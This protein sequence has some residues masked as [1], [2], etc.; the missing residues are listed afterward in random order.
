MQK[1]ISLRIFLSILLTL[2]ITF[3]PSLLSANDNPWQVEEDENIVIGTV[4]EVNVAEIKIRKGMRECSYTPNDNI[5]TAL[6]GTCSG[7]LLPLTD[8]PLNIEAEL[9]LDSDNK[10]KAMRNKQIYVPANNGAVLNGWGHNAS[11]SPNELYYTLYNW[12][13]G[14]QLYR[15]SSNSSPVF[16]SP[17]SV[18][19]WNCKSEIAVSRPDNILIL[20]PQSGKRSILA[21]PKLNDGCGRVITSINWDYNGDKLFYVSLEDY[22]DTESAIFNLTILDRVGRNVGSTIIANLDSAVWLTD[23]LILFAIYDDLEVRSG[24]ILLWN[25]ET[26]EISEFLSTEN[27]YYSNLTY[28]SELKYLAYTVTCGV[29][30]IICLLNTNNN[31]S[32]ELYKSPFP[33]KNL[34]WSNDGGLFFWDEYNNCIF[35]I[36][37]ENK[38]I[39]VSLRTGYLPTEG[40]RNSYIFFLA[41]PFEEPQ[42]VFLIKTNQADNLN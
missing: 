32:K 28:N 31:T 6:M 26:G 2:F 37:T 10:V 5:I 40:V 18:S 12:E 20:D 11:I 8:F 33:I 9:F 4:I 19:S 1:I 29:D 22:P 24:K 36:S 17:L 15:N 3:Q 16:L 38:G 7:Y 41:E 13:T 30:E 34:Q 21:L 14:L 39:A 27:G 35:K 25:Y 42:Q 23:N